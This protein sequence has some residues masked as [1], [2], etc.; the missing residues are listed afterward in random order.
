MLADM[1]LLVHSD[2]VF[3][4]FP[5]IGPFAE[6]AAEFFFAFDG[7]AEAAEGDGYADVH[8][9]VEVFELGGALGKGFVL[10]RNVVFLKADAAFDQGCFVA[11]DDF[12][13]VDQFRAR[14]DFFLVGVFVLLGLGVIVAMRFSQAC[15]RR[16]R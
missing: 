4:G 2:D 10:G 6:V 11:L 5:E 12:V 1:I 16:W 8:V 9:A 13:V 15:E 7:D 3:V 14:V